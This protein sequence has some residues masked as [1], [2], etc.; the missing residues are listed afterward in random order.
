MYRVYDL[1]FRC[2][3]LFGG[4]VTR[5]RVSKRC[6]EVRQ[7]GSIVTSFLLNKGFHL[8]FAVGFF[9]MR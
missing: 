6:T 7:I 8:K 9:R 1:G 2:S 3:R 5:F 4:G